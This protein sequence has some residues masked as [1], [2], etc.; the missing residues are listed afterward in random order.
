M[1]SAP[2]LLSVRWLFGGKL[3][4]KK[5]GKSDRGLFSMSLKLCVRL[6]KRQQCLF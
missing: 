1:S 4:M 2:G 6:S 3:C 5:T